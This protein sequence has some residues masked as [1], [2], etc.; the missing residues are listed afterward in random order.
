MPPTNPAAMRDAAQDRAR[1]RRNGNILVA[2]AVA[3]M[4]AVWAGLAWM[5][6][7]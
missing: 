3:A 1:I 7:A 4:L 2:C 5:V 6:W